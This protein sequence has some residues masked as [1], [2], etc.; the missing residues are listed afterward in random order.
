MVG[1][2]EIKYEDRAW[3]LTEVI[4]P[5]KVKH[6]DAFKSRVAAYSHLYF[7]YEVDSGPCEV[8]LYKKDGKESRLVDIARII[9]VNYIKQHRVQENQN[10]DRH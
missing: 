8:V 3:V 5:Y 10:E 4:T 2:Y 7:N 6:V 9:N 1:Y